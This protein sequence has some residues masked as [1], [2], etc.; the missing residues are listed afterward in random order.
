[1][2]HIIFLDTEI[3]WTD[4]ATVV[5][6]TGQLLAT[7]VIAVLA[8]KWAHS[9]WRK[10][11]KEEIDYQL[12]SLRAKGYFE[13]A[14]AVWGLLAFVTEKENGKC[15]LIYKGTKDKPLVYFDIDRGRAYL[16]KLS[17]VYFDEGHG[18]FI[19]KEMKQYIFHIRTNVF[20][21][22]DKEARRGVTTG[23]VL[24]ENKGAI[25]FF[26]GSFEELRAML[27]V[28]VHKELKY[29]MDWDGEGSGEE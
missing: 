26:R 23:E 29:D 16:H 9:Y 21:I 22:I 11:K 2:N 13:A 12:H 1:M 7:F 6:L 15:L 24:M 25:D 4:T 19:T 27:K 10:Q 5:V 28:Y 20:R 14:K 3:K 17:E 18:I 8:N